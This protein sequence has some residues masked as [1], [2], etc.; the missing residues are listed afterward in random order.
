MEL[1]KLSDHSPIDISLKSYVTSRNNSQVKVSKVSSAISN[2]NTLFREY[3]KQ[4]YF[5]DDSILENLLLAMEDREIMNVLK[6]ISELLDKDDLNIEIKVKVLRSK[7]V[8]ISESHFSSKKIFHQN[9]NSTSKS[10]FPWFDIECKEHKSLV[11]SKRKA[12]QAALKRFPMLRDEEAN[13][14]RPAYFQQRRIYKKL[15]RCKR[16]S[17]LERQKLELWKL[18]G[19]LK[20][21]LKKSKRQTK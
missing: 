3:N 15:I 17:F 2:E 19:K 12:Y 13:D 1:C 5:N 4:F 18:K 6:N 20:S 8:D 16:L 10:K 21:I 9:W 14:L 7:L 11:N